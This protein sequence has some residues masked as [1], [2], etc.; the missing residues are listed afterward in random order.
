MPLFSRIHF[1]LYK[2]KCPQTSMATGFRAKNNPS[3]LTYFY[4][5][6]QWSRIRAKF[7]I[8]AL[9]NPKNLDF[10]NFNILNS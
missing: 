10:S 4:F 5:S 6:A 8:L 2:E 9:R 1:F 7:Q 3:G